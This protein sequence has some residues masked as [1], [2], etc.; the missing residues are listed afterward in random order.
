M[1]RYYSVTTPNVPEPERRPC[2]P[3]PCGTNAECFEQSGKVTCKCPQDYLGDPNV[4]CR[5]ECRLNSDCSSSQTCVNSKC[6]DPC[7][8]LCGIDAECRVTNHL[9]FCVCE[10]SFTGDPYSACRPIPV[11]GK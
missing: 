5:P 6:I 4:A 3:S 11:I 9:P 10:A 1:K 2:N 8:G 7:P